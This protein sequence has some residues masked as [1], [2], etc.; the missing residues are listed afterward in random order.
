MATKYSYW[1][2]AGASSFY[3]VGS[4]NW[5]AQSFTPSE[6]HVTY[7]IKLRG[8]RSASI[9]TVTVSLRAVDGSNLPTGADLAV[10]TISE[11]GIELWEG[12]GA[13]P[14]GGT[15]FE[16]LMDTKYGLVSGREYA[17]VI[18][19]LTANPNNFTVRYNAG[20]AGTPSYSSDGDTSWNSQSGDILFEDWGT[21]LPSDPVARVSSIRHIFRPG[22]FR[23][24]VGLGDLGLDIDVAET[25]VRR[26]LDTAKAAGVGYPEILEVLGMTAEEF[27]EMGRKLA[28]GKHLEFPA[29][30]EQIAYEEWFQK[31]L[32]ILKEMQE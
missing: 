7:S 16:V 14:S 26:E 19:A 15:W 20:Y 24:Q 32:D 2:T 3:G 21:V 9:G 10:G 12:G 6:G 5:V 25:S 27:V 18:R 30:E 23:M 13:P 31:Q 29:Y 17:T 8:Y 1:D 22:F 11:G 4:D 28:T